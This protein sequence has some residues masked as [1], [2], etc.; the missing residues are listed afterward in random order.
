MAVRGAGKQLKL[1]L[2][3]EDG[4]ASL[5]YQC[6]FTPVGKDWQSVL[7]PLA[8]FRASFRRRDVSAAPA[9]DPACIR[10]VGLMIAARQAGPFNLGIR[11]IGLR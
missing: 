2:L 11:W 9:L 5:N 10:E 6:S 7:L 3:T 1:S 8:A 4:F